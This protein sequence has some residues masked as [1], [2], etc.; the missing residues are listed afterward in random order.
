MLLSLKRML[1]VVAAVLLTHTAS[2]FALLGPLDSWQVSTLGYD[3]QNDNGDIGGPKNLTEEWRWNIPDITYGF[4][5]TFIN[6]FGTNGIH[7]ITN[8][9]FLFNREMSNMSSITT[10]ML[11]AKP[12]E[13]RRIHETARALNIMDLKSTAMGLI[14]EQIGLAGAERWTWALRGR[15][16]IGGTATNYSVIQRNFD[17]F[18]PYRA[19]P[20]V[21]GFR[22]TYQIRQYP[23]AFFAADFEDA[24]SILVDQTH[25]NPGSVS[26]LVGEDYSTTPSLRLHA[27]EYFAALTRDDIGGLRYIY[28]RDNVNLEDAI[29]GTTT[30]FVDASVVNQVQGIDAYTFFTNAMFTSPSNLLAQFPNLIITSTNVGTTNI[31]TTNIFLTNVTSSTFFTNRSLGR[32]LTNLDLYVFSEAS[33]TNDANALRALYPPL[34]ITSTNSFFVTERQPV[35]TFGVAGPWSSPS[36][37]L[38]LVTNYVTNLVLNYQYTY[39]NVVTQYASAFTDLGISVVQ[40]SPWSVPGEGTLVTNTAIVRLPKTSGG[41]YIRDR[42][43]N[44]NFVDFSFVETNGAPLLRLTNIVLGTNIVF[45]NPT[46]GATTTMFNRFTNLVYGVYPIFLNGSLGDFLTTN[47]VVTTVPTFQYTFGN[48]LFFPPSNGNSNLILQTT[49]FFPPGAPFQDTI[50][51]TQPF[52]PQGTI[53]IMDT[54]QF[55]LTGSSNVFFGSVT[56]TLINFTNATTGAFVLQQL[57]RQTNGIVFFVNPVVLQQVTTASLRPGVNTLQLRPIPFTEFLGQ[58]NTISTNLYTNIVM[59]GSRLF[60]N[61]F[62]RV[63]GPDIIFAAGDLGV[64]AGGDPIGIIRNINWLNPRDGGPGIILPARTTTTSG[65]VGTIIFSTVYPFRVNQNPNALEE[66]QSAFVFSWGSF[67]NRRVVPIVY[68]EDLS[69]QVRLEQ[70]EAVALGFNPPPR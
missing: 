52:P 61:V 55:V 17:P 21:N 32:V 70:L 62:R 30:F 20:Y 8:A 19:T 11:L 33:R 68:P 41:F 10:S 50:T 45:S 5:A 35:F 25:P 24:A 37:P 42:S 27:G 60:T 36:D 39:A 64:D 44:A 28:S 51:F 2:G 22:Y 67:D 65:T 69:G 18:P 29:P 54:N 23:N 58:S 53:L 14:A 47:V 66:E 48:V 1:V 49:T 31:L 16:A 6:F 7:A 15:S 13:T 12:T 34:I 57:I 59:V 4:D 43:T 26:S 63:A 56:N 9:A 46:T 3:P 38:V 40:P